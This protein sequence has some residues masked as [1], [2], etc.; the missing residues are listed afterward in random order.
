[1]GSWGEREVDGIIV[2]LGLCIVHK[3]TLRHRTTGVIT[4]HT[5]V[6]VITLERECGLTC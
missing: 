1:M 2:M 6:L 4:R 3:I 5:T